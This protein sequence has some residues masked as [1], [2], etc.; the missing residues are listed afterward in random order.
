MRNC[1]LSFKVYFLLAP[2]VLGVAD[3]AAT[4]AYKGASYESISKLPDWSG[5][6]VMS[7]EDFGR[8]FAPGG[9][10]A[11]APYQDSYAPAKGADAHKG[12][13][14][15]C[16]PTG[17]PGI[18]GVPLGYE[19]LFNPGR[20]TILGEEGP[21]IRR[22]YTD[23][24]GHA[25][26]PDPSYA[27]DS[28]GQW[29]DNVLVVD[30]VAISPKTQFV[31]GKVKTSGSTHVI[32]RFYLSDRN[33]LRVDTEVD[34]P[35]ALTKAWRYSWTYKRSDVHFVESYY[36]DDDRDSAGEPNLTPPESN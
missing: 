9:A 25:A 1:Y 33:H 22:I 15:Q 31:G 21:L 3:S 28:V 34:D 24:R 12:N 27:G 23:G 6:W 36:C 7:D 16:L 14:S 17:M 13:A 2:F 4:P 19:F 20:V 5:T 32:E 18:M 11:I 8:L 35:I 30:T 26:D 10:A 29:Q